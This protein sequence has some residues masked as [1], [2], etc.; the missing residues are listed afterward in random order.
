MST[1]DSPEPL[2]KA[3]NPKEVEDRLYEWWEKQGYFRAY[4]DPNKKPFTIIMPPPNVTGELH[5]GHAMTAAIQDTLTRYHRMLGDMALY[6]PGTDHAGI[7]TQVVV[8]RELQK[9]NLSR[10]DVGREKFLA[11]VWEWVKSTGEKIDNQHRRL[12]A[13]CDWTR[14]TFTLDDGPAMAVRATFKNLYDEGLIYRSERMINWCVTCQTALS[15]LEVEYAEEEGHL[16]NIKYPYQDGSGYIIVATTRPETLLGD[17]AVAVHP[18]DSRYENSL[19]KLLNLPILNRPIPIITDDSV[20]TEFGTGAVKITPGHDPNDFDMGERHGLPIINILNP[21]GSLNENAGPYQGV[22]RLEA[23]KMIVSKLED[24]GLLESIT[25][26]QH[27]IGHCQRSYDIAEPIV[28]LQWFVKIKPL[29][30]PAIAA[31]EQG[32]IEIIPERFSKVYSNWM[33][34][35]RD[36]CISR[37]LWWGHRIPVWYCNDCEHENVA[38]EEPEKCGR[39]QSVN[40]QQDEDVLDTWFSSGLWP[41]STLGWP[42]KR[43]DLD[44]FYPTSVMETGYDILFF[45]VARMVM[46]GIKNI[47][48]IPFQTVYLHGLVRDESGQKMSKTKGNVR[49]PLDAI[50]QYGTDALRFAL[51]TGTAPGNDTRFSDDRLEAARNFANKLWNVGRFVLR[52]IESGV[53]LDGWN[54][55]PPRTH[56]QDRWILSKAQQTACSVNDLIQ[57]FQLGEAERVLYEFIWNDFA[58]WYIELAKIRLR[59]GDDEPR[60]VLAHVLERVLRLL[61]PFMPFVTEEIWQK[62]TSVLPDEA[63]LPESIMIAP[64]PN[65]Q[66]RLSEQELEQ[67]RL[68]DADSVNLIELLIELVRAIRNIRAEFKIEPKTLINLNLV[69]GGKNQDLASQS[70]FIQSLA[71]VG[72]LSFS[73]N[74]SKNT[75][76][77]VVQDLVVILD[78]GSTVDVVKEIHRIEQEIKELDNYSS[79][80]KVRL[81]NDQF[82]A[83]APEE[84]VAKER[85]RLDEAET[86]RLHLVELRNNL[87]NE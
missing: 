17:T 66:A 87:A 22:D 75:I 39:C 24:E 10:H 71:R 58:D 47:G 60:K 32:S 7:A 12:G 40:L 52:E 33:E 34:N 63:K 50:D 65:P 49:D 5:L 53:N 25:P 69:Q 35:I 74:D 3:Y 70:E 14:K 64:Y 55:A 41:H 1:A 48:D 68:D 51:T 26:H 23:R 72:T 80:V 76:K 36:W 28:S 6:L 77:L 27:S 37:Q 54:G 9:Q 4:P 57:N 83:K 42:S 31:V 73:P 82:I 45:W 85:V 8:E 44:Y 30:E 56:A 61:H 2:S 79:S 46:L 21:N 20:S 81:S 16:Y 67:R 11:M 86:K 13:S 18:D 62:L 43:E 38:I 19:G 29:A 78:L 15:D 84:V 59:A